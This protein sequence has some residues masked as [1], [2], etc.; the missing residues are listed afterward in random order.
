MSLTAS[1]KEFLYKVRRLIADFVETLPK[2]DTRLFDHQRT[3]LS[4]ELFRQAILI[5]ERDYTGDRSKVYTHLTTAATHY[6][7]FGV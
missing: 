3:L 2:D 1:D 4:S 7:R 6:V 5:L